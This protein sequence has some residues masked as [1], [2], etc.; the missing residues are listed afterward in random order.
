MPQPPGPLGSTRSPGKQHWGSGTG[1][2]SPSA[3][4]N[5]GPRETQAVARLSLA[6][7]AGWRGHSPAA[8]EGWS[9]PNSG[10]ESEAGGRMSTEAPPQ[11]QRAVAWTCWS[12]DTP[13]RER[14]CAVL[15]A[16]GVLSR[17]H[18]GA[19]SPQTQ[20]PP[21]HHGDTHTAV[22]EHAGGPRVGRD[23]PALG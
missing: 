14:L 6:E 17:T 18:V 9:N 10:Q 12:R 5:A 20:V 21:A 15:V 3:P 23:D 13:R 4:T 8:K 2:F 19:R 11:G 1:P 22:R 16:V 7:H